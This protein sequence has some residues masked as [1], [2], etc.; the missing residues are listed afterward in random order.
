MN[1]YITFYIIHVIHKHKFV[2]IIGEYFLPDYP[3]H[4]QSAK[5]DFINFEGEVYEMCFF[6]KSKY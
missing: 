2:I 6:S 1:F 4:K 5:F 3:I